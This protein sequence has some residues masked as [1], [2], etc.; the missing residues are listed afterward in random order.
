M[1]FNVY[2]EILQAQNSQDTLEELHRRDSHHWTLRLITKMQKLRNCDIGTRAEGKKSSSLFKRSLT[3]TQKVYCGFIRCRSNKMYDNNSTKA[4]RREMKVSSCKVL[5]VYV[6]LYITCKWTDT[7]V[8]C[9][10]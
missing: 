10:F 2:M 5:T 7:E 1:T 8:H 9:T 4:K 3:K 6:K